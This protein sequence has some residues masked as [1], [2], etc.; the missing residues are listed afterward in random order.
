MKCLIKKKHI[1]TYKINANINILCDVIFSVQIGK[2]VLK[3][4]INKSIEIILLTKKKNVYYIWK[5]MC[6]LSMISSMFINNYL[7]ITND[8]ITDQ[9]LQSR[10]LFIGRNDEVQNQYKKK[11]FHS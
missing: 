5:W 9:T 1:S 10:F 2:H 6:P 11:S 3:K 8:K 4:T 7:A